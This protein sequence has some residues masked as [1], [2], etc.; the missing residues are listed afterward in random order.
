MSG[1][2]SFDG[3]NLSDYGL[4]VLSDSVHEILAPITLRQMKFSGFHGAHDF[5]VEYEP[6]EW[7]LN[8]II[9]GSSL[10]D[11]K[12]KMDSIAALLDADK[13]LKKLIFDIQTDRYWLAKL[14]AALDFSFEGFSTRIVVMLIAPSPFALNIDLIESNFSIT[15]AD[16][17]IFEIVGG[18]YHALPQWVFTADQALD[19]IELTVGEGSTAEQFKWTGSLAENDILIVDT[20]LWY[21]TKN[22]D[23]AMA[24]VEGMFPRLAPGAKN[25]INIKNFHG[26]LDIKYQNKYL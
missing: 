7:N 2:F 3:I 26:S 13:G 15:S 22:G 23:P 12:S 25:A 16:Q 4:H 11:L 18:T 19:D 14:S 9:I 5:G 17:N 10:T 24:N 6:R 20:N 21:V 8:C 1:S